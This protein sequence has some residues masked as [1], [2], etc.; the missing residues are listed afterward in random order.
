[1]IFSR[2]VISFTFSIASLVFAQSIFDNNNNNNNDINW[3]NLD[4]SA[5][6]AISEPN[7]FDNHEADPSLNPNLFSD[8]GSND[9]LAWEDPI[10]NHKDSSSSSIDF[11]TDAVIDDNAAAA[12]CLSL[13]TDGLQARSPTQCPNPLENP[14]SDSSTS[15]TATP[16]DVNSIKDVFEGPQYARP[17][18]VDKKVC[19]FVPYGFRNIP[20]C[21]SGLHYD[22]F[23]D[24]Y[25]GD[26][27]L[28]NP[29]VCTCDI[30][31]V[32]FVLHQDCLFP[33][34]ENAFCVCFD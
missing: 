22:I 24:T 27:E 6:L 34:L 2:I 29:T 15:T 7:L 20:L 10:T 19:P 13:G 30:I 17:D 28:I 18:L 31:N 33:L 25:T 11:M 12:L 5:N 3:N 9:N 23:E 26:I 32:G 8:A 4:N 14:D 1:M 21:D 16:N